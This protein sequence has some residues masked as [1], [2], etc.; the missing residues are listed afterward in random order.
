VVGNIHELD[1]CLAFKI[2]LFSMNFHIGFYG[3]VA[4]RKT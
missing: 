2:D 3:L 4:R 1:L